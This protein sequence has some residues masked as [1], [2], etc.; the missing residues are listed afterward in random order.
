M[1]NNEATKEEKSS[2]DRSEIMGKMGKLWLKN[3]VK[4]LESRSKSINFTPF[5]MVDTSAL[6][7][8]LQ[9]VKNIVKTREFVVL[10]PKAGML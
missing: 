9:I 8:Y 2:E 6:I 7:Y 1:R 3:E 4:N 5:L 10:I